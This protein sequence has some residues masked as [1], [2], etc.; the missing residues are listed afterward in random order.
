MNQQ[1]L[2]SAK[3]SARSSQHGGPCKRWASHGT[4][5]CTSHGARAPQ[6]AFKAEERI[7]ALAPTA[8][9]TL[10]ALL[11]NRQ[12]PAVRLGAARDLLDRAGLAAIERVDATVQVSD[13]SEIRARLLSS[14]DELATRRR[15]RGV[16]EQAN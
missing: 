8:L 11:D 1:T 6:V 15:T 2:G 4:N 13:V 10:A 16:A 7:R 3:C 14:L 5:V 12:P 9:D